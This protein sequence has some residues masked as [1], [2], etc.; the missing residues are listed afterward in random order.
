MIGK[1]CIA[2]PARDEEELIAGTIEAALSYGDVFV[3]DNNSI[4]KTKVRG[5]EAGATVIH[6]H[7][8]GYENVIYH[9]C[10]FFLGSA[11]D[12]LV[13]MDGDGEVGLKELDSALAKLAD[14]DGVIGSRNLKKRISER[15]V[16]RIFYSKTRIEDVM[17]GF[18]VLRRTAISS[19]LTRKTYGTGVINK[20]AKFTN[21]D[22][23]VRERAGTRLGGEM[24]VQI[25]IL[26]CGLRGYFS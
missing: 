7:N 21:V 22:V 20:S 18:K 13:I 14:V 16:S 11:Y 10:D 15:M 4:D 3:F 19:T 23:T 12:C 9:I 8:V 17:C 24:K 1:V 26:M 25:D 6:S 5:E 2:L